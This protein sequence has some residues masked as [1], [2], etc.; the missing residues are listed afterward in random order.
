[1]NIIN[2]FRESSEALDNYQSDWSIIDQSDL[3]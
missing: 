1:M 3:A 2:S